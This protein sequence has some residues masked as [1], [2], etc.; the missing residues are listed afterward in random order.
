MATLQAVP[1]RHHHTEQVSG[2]LTNQHL[3][4]PN[5][6]RDRGMGKKTQHKMA[7]KQ[8]AIATI[9]CEELQGS[10]CVYKS[11]DAPARGIG[12]PPV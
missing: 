4:G 7:S 9:L 12:P 1:T 3:T 8:Q 10:N 2:I 5:L 11:Q 6:K